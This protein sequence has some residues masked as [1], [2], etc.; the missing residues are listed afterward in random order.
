MKLKKL[1]TISIFTLIIGLLVGCGGN[2][3]T[4]TSSKTNSKPLSQ[5]EVQHMFSNPDKFKGRSIDIYAKIFVEPEK[6]DNGTYLQAYADPKSLS[7]NILIKINDPKLDVKNEDIIHIV[8]KIEKKFEGEN[9]LGG[10]VTAP[11]ITADKIEKA[12]Y[13]EAFAP[14]LKTIDINKETNQNGYVLKLNKVEIAKDETRAYVTV[15]N[16]TKDKIN[17]YTFN[18]KLVQGT[19]QI[20][21]G[22]NYQGNYKQINDEIMP[23]VKE[24]GIVLFKQVDPKGDNLKLHFEGSSENYELHFEP[25]TFEVK[26]K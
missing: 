5:E 13:A 19:K 3:S 11:V 21:E 14:A 9:A 17:F 10:K 24:E 8:G 25:F 23:G 6:D 1:I 12:D 20:Q 7:K 18:S 26:L 2:S 4:S 16:N 22:E 15:T